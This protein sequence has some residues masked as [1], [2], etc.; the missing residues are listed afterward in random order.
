MDRKI[1]EGLRPID[2]TISPLIRAEEPFTV[3]QLRSFLGSYKQLTEC[4]PEY[5]VLLSPLEKL[6]A[7]LESST[8]IQWT[9]EFSNIFETE[10]EA[11]NKVE[12]IFIPKPTDKLEIYVDYSQHKKAVGGKMMIR[13]EDTDNSRRTLLGEH[14]SCKLDV[15]QKNW[16]PCEG[17]ALGVKLICK[18]FSPY[19]RESKNTTTVYTD[20]L[21]TVQAWRRM[22]TGAFSASA[23][24]AS[25][26]TG[27]SSLTVEVVHKPGNDHQ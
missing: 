25:F 12:N 2:H 26:L 22:K 17:E 19:I 4:I 24:V 5:A 7:G 8:R 10:K 18:H 16:L 1:G 23:R 21:P 6:V 15:H 13:R 20:N 9:P 27:L 14:F 11:L 3:K